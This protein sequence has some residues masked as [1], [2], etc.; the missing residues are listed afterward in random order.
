MQAVNRS[1]SLILRRTIAMVV[2]WLVAVAFLYA[3]LYQTTQSTV[4]RIAEEKCELATSSFQG[5]RQYEWRLEGSGPSWYC[6]Y[7]NDGEQARYTQSWLWPVYIFNVAVLPLLV[8]ALAY[9]VVR[10]LVIKAASLAFGKSPES[11]VRRAQTLESSLRP[12]SRE[13][14]QG[15]PRILGG[16]LRRIV[17]AVEDLWPG[18]WLGGGVGLG[19]GA[20]IL[21]ADNLITLAAAT[22]PF[23]EDFLVSL[24]TPAVALTA[25]LLSFTWI[26]R[27][28][29]RDT[30]VHRSGPGGTVGVPSWKPEH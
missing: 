5:Q 21:L 9:A 3:Y 15:W 18:S 23:R 27:R 25:G 20:S 22:F 24:P 1:E 29:D 19:I 7:R 2:A 26:R 8:S 4:G 13:E 6:I 10:W 17:R 28:A 30:G 11:G 14:A 16:W 12:P